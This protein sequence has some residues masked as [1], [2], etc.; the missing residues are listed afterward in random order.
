M[1]FIGDVWQGPA[2]VE[3]QPFDRSKTVET[4]NGA[5]TRVATPGL[6]AVYN[7]CTVDYQLELAGETETGEE[8]HT[9]R[10]F[11]HRRA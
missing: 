7:L 9:I 2:V 8:Q 10:Y 3:T 6:D 11:F 1:R 5:L 4:N